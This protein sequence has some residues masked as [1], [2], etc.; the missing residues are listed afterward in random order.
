MLSRRLAT[1]LLKRPELHS[2]SSQG[3]DFSS[4][5]KSNKAHSKSNKKSSKKISPSKDQMY[6][7]M[8]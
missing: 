2:L 1:L 3:V 7:R 5:Q 8:A 4:K 6:D